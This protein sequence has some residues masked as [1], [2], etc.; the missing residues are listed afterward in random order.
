M[1]M[2]VI[3]MATIGGTGTI[4]G[5][6]IAAIVLY[7]TTELLRLAGAVFSQVAIGLLLMGFILFLPDGI[8]GWLRRRRLARSSSTGTVS[9]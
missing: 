8:A 9:P 7:V 6:A 3:A 2:L 4:I 5:P 1:T